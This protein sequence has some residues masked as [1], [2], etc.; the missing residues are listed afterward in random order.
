MDP[1]LRT[2]LGGPADP[3]DDTSESD[4]DDYE[5]QPYRGCVGVPAT[6]GWMLSNRGR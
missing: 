4:G 5:P 3:A 1:E 2:T 6:R